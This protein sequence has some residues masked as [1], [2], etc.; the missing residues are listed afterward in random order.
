MNIRKRSESF[1]DDE[2]L[3]QLLLCLPDVPNAHSQRPCFGARLQ[4][5]VRIR[6]MLRQPNR[7]VERRLR[8]LPALLPSA[9][10]PLHLQEIHFG[11]PVAPHP[12]PLEALGQDRFCLVLLAYLQTAPCQWSEQQRNLRH[13]G[14]WF[15]DQRSEMRQGRSRFSIK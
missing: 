6:H 13:A 15:M 14:T 5:P 3:L 7:H 4:F 1:G 12:D 8:F 10:H 9:D 2:G 11:Q